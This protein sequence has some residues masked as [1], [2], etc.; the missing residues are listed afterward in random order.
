MT[1]AFLLLYSASMAAREKSAER[2]V[3]PASTSTGP[4]TWLDTWLH[5]RR[6]APCCRSCRLPSRSSL[7]TEKLL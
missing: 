1:D 6:P 5:V 3:S 7:H 4:D 2:S